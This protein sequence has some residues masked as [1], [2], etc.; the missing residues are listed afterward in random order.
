MQLCI[1]MNNTMYDLSDQIVQAN[2]KMTIEM[3]SE[4]QVIPV[5]SS[6]PKE[7]KKELKKFIKALKKV[8]NW[9]SLPEDQLE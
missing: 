8:Y 7:E 2:L 4:P 9:Y 5:F 3:L 6:D 1:E